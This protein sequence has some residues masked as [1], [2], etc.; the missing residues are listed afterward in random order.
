MAGDAARGKELYDA[1]VAALP[2]PPPVRRVA[3]LE[4][5]KPP[6]GTVDLTSLEWVERIHL[7]KPVL[8]ALIPAEDV[9]RFLDGEAARCECDK[10]T[11]CGNTGSYCLYRCPCAGEGAPRKAGPRKVRDRGHAQVGSKKVGCEARFAVTVSNTPGVAHLR[12]LC[13]EH[14]TA[15]RVQTPRNVSLAARLRVLLWL[16]ADPG[17]LPHTLVEKNV[18]FVAAQYASRNGCSPKEAVKLFHEVRLLRPWTWAGCLA[19][20]A[21]AAELPRTTVTSS[22]ASSARARRQPSR[23]RGAGGTGPRAGAN[24]TVSCAPV[25]L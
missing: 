1:A 6:A 25:G 21:E 3:Q 22:C 19:G 5:Q 10:Y 16:R 7:G 24:S 15:C 8:E 2:P 9:Q 13:Y 18:G 4:L 20:V 14:A 11:K 17:L 23:G 12:Y